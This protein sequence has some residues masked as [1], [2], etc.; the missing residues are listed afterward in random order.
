MDTHP[1]GFDIFDGFG[2]WSLLEREAQQVPAEQQL[3]PAT[4]ATLQQ[5]TGQTDATNIDC[6]DPGIRDFLDLYL[7]DVTF[8]SHDFTDYLKGNNDD[9]GGN[10]VDASVS[11]ASADIQTEP[12]PD[13]TA[14]MGATTV[15]TTTTAFNGTATVPNTHIE[16]DPYVHD[17][18]VELDDL[19]DSGLAAAGP[20]TVLLQPQH[21][22]QQMLQQPPD[23]V[24]LEPV[25]VTYAASGGGEGRFGGGGITGSSTQQEGTNAPMMP[26]SNGSAVP[27]LPGNGVHMP[28]I[29]GGGGITGRSTQQEGTNAPMMPYNNG[30]A[31]PLLPGNGVHMP[32]IF[33][34]GGITGRSTQQEGTNAP[35]MPYNNGS[36]EPVL[37]GNGVHMPPIFGGGGITGSS[38][39]QEGTNAL[40]MSYNNGSAEPVL[41]GN[42]VH[43]PPI[44]GGGGITGSS[45]QQEGTNAPMMPYNNGS[46]EPVLPGNGVHMPPIFG[47]GGITGSSTQQE[48]TNAPMMPYNNGSAEPVLPGN[49]V[50]IPPNTAAGLMDGL[51]GSGLAAA[52]QPGLQPQHQQ[53]L[54]QTLQ[55][56]FLQVAG[57][58]GLQQQLLQVLQQLSLLVP[59]SSLMPYSNGSAEQGLPGN[60][61]HMPPNTAA[62]LMDGLPGSGLATAGQLGLQP[63]GQQQLLQTLQQPYVQ[64]HQAPVD[65]NYVTSGA[66]MPSPDGGDGSGAA[67]AQPEPYGR[68]RPARPV[69]RRRPTLPENADN[70]ASSGAVGAAATS[71]SGVCPLPAAAGTDTMPV[72][73]NCGGDSGSGDLP[74]Q[75]GSRR[76][77]DGAGPS[78]RRRKTQGS[79]SGGLPTQSGSSRSGDGAGPSKRRRKT[80]G[81]GSDGPTSRQKNKGSSLKKGV[82]RNVNTK[83]WEAHYWVARA[84]ALCSGRDRG[85]QVFCGG[86]AT[87]EAAAAAYDLAAIMFWGKKAKTNFPMDSYDKDD[88]AWLSKVDPFLA[89]KALQQAAGEG[90]QPVPDLLRALLPAV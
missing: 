41:P 75:S 17:M 2:G 16:S 48:G 22:Q 81:S 5:F 79:G 12:H 26:Y 57:Q 45:T 62:G 61:V 15:I 77:G 59:H 4:A 73:H 64:V 28:P 46:A 69:H 53:Q 9:N 39:Q 49:G 40:M 65:V 8:P 3:P 51:P 90:K 25:H 38:T 67:D 31:E 19:P 35:M 18:A 11:A 58:P 6:D 29:F 13:R 54:L 20:P 86:F 21:Q 70:A 43:M 14:A 36:A 34:G 47:G 24:H 68:E 74:T 78:K 55:H 83:K 27:V 33:G 71:S 66:F 56:L 44:F 23:Q 85:M 89:S 1:D 50:H 72:Q 7:P 52:G 88:V 76:S 32:P 60:G 42:G 87:E 80:Q 10:E 82:C 63:Q 30:S 84:H 37:P